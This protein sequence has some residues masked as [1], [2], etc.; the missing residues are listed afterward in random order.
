MRELTHNTWI[1]AR[2]EFVAY[3]STPLATIFLTVFVPLSVE[4]PGLFAR[5][6]V[7]ELPV[8]LKPVMRFPKPS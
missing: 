2:R 5:A 4:P 7:T 8:P 3:F 1:I 6:T